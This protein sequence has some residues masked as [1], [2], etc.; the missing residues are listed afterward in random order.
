MLLGTVDIEINK[1]DWVLLS[2]SLCIYFKIFIS[3]VV[4][5]LSCDTW[6]LVS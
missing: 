5:G 2:S 4:P 1:I 3:L 6:G